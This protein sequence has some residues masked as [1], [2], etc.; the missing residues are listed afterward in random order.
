MF[1]FV[2]SCLLKV[3]FTGD[4]VRVPYWKGQ[5]LMGMVNCFLNPETVIALFQLVVCPGLERAGG[6]LH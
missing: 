4:T 2:V 1:L 5:K 6:S 3:A